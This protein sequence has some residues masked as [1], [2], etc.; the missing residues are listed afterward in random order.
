MA[1]MTGFAQ[2]LHNYEYWVDDNYDTR[3]LSSTS[4]GSIN[5]SFDGKTM[6]PGIHYFNVRAQNSSGRWGAL[7]REFFYLPAPVTEKDTSTVSSY[8]Y[9]VD[10]NYEGRTTKT[11][12]AGTIALTLDGKTMSPGIHYFNVRAQNSNGR[13]G[14]LHREFFYLPAPV[15]EKDTS[16]VSSYEYWVDNNYEGRTTKTASAGTITLSL[17]GKTM[18]PGI[19]YFNVRAQNSSGRWGSVHREFF[20][21]PDKNI[22]IVSNEDSLI[23]G[24][25]YTF[26]DWARYEAI[27]PCAEYELKQHV[28]QIPELSG[29]GSL[30]EGCSW[31]F[32]EKQVTLYRKN[33]TTFSI[34]FK[35]EAGNWSVPKGEQFELSDTISKIPHVLS[36]GHQTTFQK[37][38]MGNYEPI[39]IRVDETRDYYLQTSQSCRVQLFRSNGTLIKTIGSEALKAGERCSLT[40]GTTYYAI[41]YRMLKD[42]ENP[43]DLLS[44]KL[45][46]E[47]NMVLT[48]TISYKQ[49]IVTISSEQEGA[50]IYYT[51][52]G[53][54][55]TTESSR[56]TEPFALRHNA[57]IKAIACV[58][59]MVAS[60]VTSYV[61]NSYKVAKPV[62]SSNG[63]WL[64]IHTD[65]PD[66]KIFYTT[67]GTTPDSN[68]TEYVEAIRLTENCTVKAIALKEYFNDS[69]VVTYQ[70]VAGNVVTETPVIAHEGNAITITTKEDGDIVYY[71]LDGSTPTKESTRYTGP[72]EVTRNGEVKAIATRDNYFDSEIAELKV[73]WFKVATPEFAVDGITLTI[74]C[75]TEDVSIY[76]NIGSEETPSASATLY[77]GPF[78]L[79]DNQP[80]KAIAIRDGY[81]DSEVALFAESVVTSRGVTLAYN[82]RFVT[83]TPE[84]DNAKVYYT[85]DGTEP[86]ATSEVYTDKIVIDQLLTVKAT[87]MRPYTNMSAVSSMEVTYFYDGEQA[88]VKDRG[89]LAKSFEWCGTDAVKELHVS[90]P[91]GTDEWQTLRSLPN[92]TTLD[93]EKA[94][95]DGQALPDNALQGATMRWVVIPA[96]LSSVG[97]NVF[98]DCK[99][100]AAIT[101]N[102]TKVQLTADALG[103]HCNPNMLFYVP[104]ENM[105]GIENANVISNGRARNIVLYDGTD[106]HDFY[107]PTAFSA[108]TISYTHNFRQTTEQGVCQGWETLALPFTVQTITHWKNGE[109]VP[110]AARQQD[111]SRKPFWL[112]ELG[113][114]GFV[115]ADR[116]AANVP[117]ILSMP[118]D[119]NVYADRNL[120]AGEVTFSAKNVDVPVTDIDG[121]SSQMGDVYFVSNYSLREPSANIY[122]INLHEAYD[123]THPEGS[124]FLPNYRQ[125][126]P[127]EAYTTSGAATAPHYIA[128]ADLSDKTTGIQNVMTDSAIVDTSDVKV[129]NLSGTLV[130][131]GNRSEVMKRLP[132]GIYIINNRKVVVK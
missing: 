93:I 106:Y 52:D 25:Q 1:V 84:E 45:L 129:Y 123:A 36:V 132:K 89:L 117:Y 90:G 121:N 13:W 30:E 8:E 115:S 38:S 118:N 94:L 111:D 67:D 58:E 51:L 64:S 27:T 44:V 91:I 128:I 47:P 7:H 101:W 87:A 57:T 92:L 55:P 76:Y 3:V 85:L 15:T 77:T 112:A 19:H 4:D 116:I 82:G 2:S 73:D 97:K 131:S 66:A 107:C 50:T 34:R 46:L 80:I 100:L 78:E 29:F 62:F 54:T 16:T 28:F 53:T 124:I 22:K 37:V 126:R 104:S 125:L 18:S 61:V 86:T 31:T 102:T 113:E 119:S 56:Y 114:S 63:Y 33:S 75:A 14:A 120:L 70:F 79:I 24:Y 109:M 98:A 74:S 72:F 42:E 69:E 127:F 20:F 59:G 88:V 6:S 130:T 103:E 48:P 96:D 21:L 108:Y 81:H 9:W 71:T 41:V 23:V 35:N 40:A 110:F 26:G 49:E 68:S 105:V 43:A 10:N 11:A 122:A 5:L 83:I 32:N 17:D 99:Q 95:L 39:R 12:S 65:T 60:E